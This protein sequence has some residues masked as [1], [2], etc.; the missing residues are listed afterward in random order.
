MPNASGW[1]QDEDVYLCTAYTNTSEDGATSTD[2][3]SRSFWD[4]VH[5]TFTQLAGPG[6]IGRNAGA[7]QSRWSGLIRPDVAL[8]ASLIAT[9]EG[10]KHSGWTD[11]EVYNAACE[12]F[13]AKREQQNQNA[14]QEYER[15]LSEGRAK[16][17]RKPRAKQEDFRLKHCFDVLSKSVRFMRDV[18]MPRKRP[19]AALEPEPDGSGFDFLVG[20]NRESDDA[21]DE[22]NSIKTGNSSASSTAEFQSPTRSTVPVR[23]TSAGKKKMKQMQT[24]EQIDKSTM[25]SQRQ[26]ATASAAQVEI[27]QKQLEVA[28]QKNQILASQQQAMVDQQEM[29]LMCTST[30]GLSD[31]GKEFLRIKE[32]QLLE[33]LKKNLE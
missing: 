5:S 6:A 29:A 10:E 3:S 9:V 2:Q 26:L 1:T 30:D 11:V 21:E 24:E 13:S 23:P 25:H 32:T 33:R 18:P 7:L 28:K 20:E 22:V 15:S 14:L 31:L 12:R 27:M 16:T 19:A 8:F 17:K 4:R